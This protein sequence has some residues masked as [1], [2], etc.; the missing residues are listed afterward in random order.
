MAF[1][2]KNKT[3]ANEAQEREILL[4]VIDKNLNIE[5]LR[6]LAI[7]ANNTVLKA[8]ALTELNKL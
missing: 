7:I 8:L 2:N 3:T 1:L 6:K 5:Q 4:K